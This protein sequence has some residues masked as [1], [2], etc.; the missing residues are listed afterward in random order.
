LGH[1]VESVAAICIEIPYHAVGVTFQA[2]DLWMSFLEISHA[3]AW[4]LANLHKQCSK[5]ISN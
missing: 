1:I 2:C 3:T 5:Y 4:V